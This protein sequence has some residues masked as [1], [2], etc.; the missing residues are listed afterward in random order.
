MMEPMKPETTH[1]HRTRPRAVSVL[2]T[3]CTLGNCICGFASLC[4]AAKGDPL[5]PNVPI[6]NFAIAGYLIFAAMIFD[7]L[8]GRMARLAKA[9]SD[10]GGELDSLADMVSFGAAP[11]FLAIQLSGMLVS[12]G[13]LEFLGPL[14]DDAGGRLV[15]IIGAIYVS[16]AALR[17]ARFNV[18][19]QHKEEAHLNFRGLPSP[20][21]AG[22]V[23]ASVIFFH[24]VQPMAKHH[25]PFHLPEPFREMASTS[26]PY[27]LPAILLAAGLLMVSRFEYVHVVN[28]YLRGRKSFSYV[29][30]V[31]LLALLVVWQP[32]LAALLLIYAYA[33]S[34]P[35]AWF[36]SRIFPKPAPATPP[37]VILE[38]RSPNPAETSVV[39]STRHYH[40]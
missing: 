33:V 31:V 28:Q 36:W 37:V 32:Q 16:C 35:V 15:W 29:A 18:H 4:Y 10:F 8:D 21:A 19:N 26:F 20:G 6:S 14:A 30:R 22:V 23:A 1:K 7:M 34:A 27:V 39:E 17:L 5:W 2:P 40:N 9:T 12:E 3:L 38:S 13:K 11:A 24:T 25:M